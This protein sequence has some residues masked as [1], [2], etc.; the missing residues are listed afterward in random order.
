MKNHDK[1]VGESWIF[2]TYLKNIFLSRINEN[3]GVVQIM[4]IYGVTQHY[5]GLIGNNAFGIITT[6]RR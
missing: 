4:P 1:D 3:E 6:Q 5:S 2:K